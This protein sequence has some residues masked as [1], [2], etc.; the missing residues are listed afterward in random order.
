MT[1]LKIVLQ[2]NY[3]YITLIIITA[4]YILIFTKV[5][6]YISKYTINDSAITGKIISI[7]ESE[8]KISLL[9]KGKE[10]IKATYYL[11]DNEKVDLNIGDNITIHGKNN[12]PSNNTLPN[13]FNFKK[14]LYNNKIYYTFT[15]NSL[16]VNYHSKNPFIIIK[17][18]ITKKC[19]Y[20]KYLSLFILGDKSHLEEKIYNNLKNIG[21]AHLIAVSG[22]HISMFILI[23]NYLLYFFKDRDKNIIIII[24]LILY[25]YLTGFTPSVERVVIMYILGIINKRYLL[26]I[27]SLKLLLMTGTII[28]LIN[29]FNIY[30]TSFL[31][32]MSC[33]FGIIAS[34]KYHHKNYIL[35]MIITTSL[36]MLFTLPIT[37]N[38]NYEINLILL[39]S[40]LLLI[41]FVSFILYPLTLITFI[42]PFLIKIY[43]IVVFIFESIINLFSKIKLTIYLPKMPFYIIIIYYLLL[44]LFIYFYHKRYLVLLA[45]LLIINKTV[46][47]LNSNYIIGLLDVGQGDSTLIIS[48]NHKNV[49]LIDTGGLDYYSTINNTLLYLKSIGITKIN[50]L[51][52]SHGDFD[53][54]GEAIN[55]VNNF[56]VEKVIFNCGE[57]NN[58]EQQLM[59]L[60]DKKKITYYSCINELNIDNNKLYFL[61]TKEYDNENDNSN[62]I[63]TEID[64]YKFMFMGDASIATE[65]A[66]LKKY[67]LSKIDVLKVGHHGSKTSSGEEFINELN[68][69]YSIISVGKNNRYGHPNKEVLDN[70]KDTKIYR[71]DQD[72]S[73]MFKIKNNKLKIETCSP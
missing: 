59:K 54:M 30:S 27:S 72:G 25:S 67:K 45:F 13:T 9:V 8:D 7:N 52:I 61:Q 3:L 18:Y 34:K 39:L 16:N 58:L 14:Y 26:N 28:L 1:R 65:N 40:N 4:L 68:P 53:H 36:L 2:S 73:I 46:Y 33:A 11:K 49:T 60:L 31:Y 24:F 47:L 64:G 50:N 35:N 57:F 32:S 15:I 71:T 70:L 6:S 44:I 55:L 56:K 66:I 12:I 29:P 41:P 63:Y 62:V 19:S 42:F 48:P 17:N 51:I 5:C 43:N 20:S 37:I 23:L 69:K 22:M 38:Q 21:A 10:K